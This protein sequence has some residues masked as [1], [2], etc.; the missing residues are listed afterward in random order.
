VREG[1]G[2]RNNVERIGGGEERGGARGGARAARVESNEGDNS[3]RGDNGGGMV[4]QAFF[5]ELAGT[6]GYGRDGGGAMQ[7]ASETSVTT[8]SY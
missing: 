8:R 5:N 3:R 7:K 6:P 2:R 4:N 1:S